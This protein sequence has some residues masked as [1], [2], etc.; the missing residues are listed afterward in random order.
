MKSA[1]LACAALLAFSTPVAAQNDDNDFRLRV[2]LG[3]QIKPSYVGSDNTDVLPFFDLDL[4]RGNN[5]F[6][7]E[8]PDDVFSIRLFS[9][10]GFAAGPTANLQGKRKESDVGAPV[11]KVSRTVEVGGFAEYQVS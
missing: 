6:A 3:G 9:K 7:F 2:G 4:A 10:G 8:A 1:F 5:P 11:G